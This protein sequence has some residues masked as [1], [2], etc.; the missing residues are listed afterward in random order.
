MNQ[1]T[2]KHS[3]LLTTGMILGLSVM[4]CKPIDK[5]PTSMDEQPV[6]HYR[7]LVNDPTKFDAAM[8]KCKEAPTYEAQ[9]NSEWCGVTRKAS[10]CET[11]RICPEE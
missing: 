10:E 8:L 6:P 3:S 1:S 4:A 2:F 7:E 11:H 5:A 9:L